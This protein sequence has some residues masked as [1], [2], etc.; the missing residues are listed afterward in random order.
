MLFYIEMDES[1]I[2]GYDHFGKAK[3][4]AK[5]LKK[6]YPNSKIYIRYSTWYEGKKNYE[7]I[8]IEI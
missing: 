8:K 6:A 4:K 7:N 2:I 1:S 3:I 5:E